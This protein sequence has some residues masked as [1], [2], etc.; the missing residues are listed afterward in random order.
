MNYRQLLAYFRYF[1]I[2]VFLVQNNMDKTSFSF[3]HMIMIFCPFLVLIPYFFSIFVL[4]FK[5]FE[6]E[7]I[8]LQLCWFFP[9]FIMYFKF[10]MLFTKNELGK[11]QNE[12]VQLH[13][14]NF[15]TIWVKYYKSRVLAS[16]T[17]KNLQSKSNLFILH[18][19]RF[20]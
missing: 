10:A 17:D 11:L 12:V 16:K 9:T 14:K 7:V 5:N 6:I 2:W 8:Q 1:T 13:F 4:F 20:S 19:K 3:Y 15:Q 18:R